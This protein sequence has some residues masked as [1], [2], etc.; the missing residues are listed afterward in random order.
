MSPQDR[1]VDVDVP[2]LVQGYQH[3]WHALL[4]DSSAKLNL[5]C[6]VRGYLFKPNIDSGKLASLNRSW[7]GTKD[8]FCA[9]GMA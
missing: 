4:R 8:T 9:L 1:L 7:Q 2:S 3:W 6:N 5:A